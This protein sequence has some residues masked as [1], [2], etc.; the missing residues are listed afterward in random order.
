MTITLPAVPATRPERPGH[1]DSTVGSFEAARAARIAELR[2]EILDGTYAVPATDVADV[3]I[4]C[5][6][7][8]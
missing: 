3:M 4:A 2:Q 8:A 5:A 1:T 7:T 6:T